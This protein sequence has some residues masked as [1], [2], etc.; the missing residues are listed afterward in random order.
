MD[1]D[2]QIIK[3][4]FRMVKKNICQAAPFLYPVCMSIDF[5]AT[6]APNEEIGANSLLWTDG[7]QIFYFSSKIMELYQKKTLIQLE[8]TLLH[9]LLH[10]IMGHFEQRKGVENRELYDLCA[11]IEVEDILGKLKMR[12][13]GCI[14]MKSRHKAERVRNCRELYVQYQQLIKNGRATVEGLRKKNSVECRDNHKFWEDDTLNQT[15]FDIWKDRK[16]TMMLNASSKEA[17]WLEGLCHIS[18]MQ[19]KL[20]DGKNGS[21]G[22]DTENETQMV[23]LIGEGNYSFS[24]ILKDILDIQENNQENEEQ[25]DKALYSYGLDTYGDVA[26]IEPVDE[27]EDK[28]KLNT[29][30]IAIDTSGSCAGDLVQ[31]F[32]LETRKLFTE[33]QEEY[34]ADSI[35]IIQC[36]NQIQEE[37][38]Y[39]SIES[40]LHN[41]KIKIKGFG[42]T[43]FRPV[44][45]RVKEL[46][47]NNQIGCLMYF[48]DGEGTFPRK[49][50]PYKSVFIMEE[51]DRNASVPGWIKCYYFNKGVEEKC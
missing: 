18:G 19:S 21:W 44:F 16:S 10:G 49:E 48:S 47:K 4:I 40:F 6:E 1:K 27:Q 14:E 43:D 41:D 42:G 33:I 15:E 25:F 29:I 39:Y 50:Q 24:K 13:D 38:T 2:K 11:D 20:N 26:L 5:V 30:V 37:V 8:K 45:D 17:E 35:V 23:E 22:D 9:I 28:K 46:Q 51:A 34:C 7:K 32:L 3:D 12:F 36:D 31:R